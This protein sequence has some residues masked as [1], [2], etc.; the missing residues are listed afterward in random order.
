MYQYECLGLESPPP[1]KVASFLQGYWGPWRE[2]FLAKF[3]EAQSRCSQRL[4]AEGSAAPDGSERV[5]LGCTVGTL[6]A[7]AC[8]SPGATRPSSPLGKEGPLATPVPQTHTAVWGPRPVPLF[9]EH[10]R[11]ASP[12]S[13]VN[14]S[15]IL[16]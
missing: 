10:S 15:L 14:R 9:T 5:K 3:L 16:N 6:G 2:S 11:H 13:R 8:R 4:R 12:P 7:K 1:A